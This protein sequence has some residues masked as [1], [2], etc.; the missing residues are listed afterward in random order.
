MGK[1]FSGF[2]DTNIFFPEFDKMWFIIGAVIMLGTCIS[3]IPQI[4]LIIKKKS[5]LGLNPVTIFIT[6]VNQFLSIMN[7]LSLH[8]QDFLGVLQIDFGFRVVSRLMTFFNTLSL[9]VAYLP[10]VYLNII[11]LDSFFLLKN[12]TFYPR[13]VCVFEIITLTICTTL[14]F[15]FI[16]KGSILGTACIAYGKIIGTVSTLIVF[17]Q[18]LPQI[19][20]TYKLKSSGALSVAMLCIQAPGGMLNAMFMM[21]GQNDDWT[22]W[23]PFFVASLDQFVLLG[24][25]IYF[26]KGKASIE[27]SDDNRLILSDD[28]NDINELE[29]VPH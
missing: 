8:A 3:V 27:D 12:R 20:T 23:F 18:Y 17:V 21:I 13:F 5:S 10:I 26:N 6:S 2:V 28:D 9:W 15:I 29:I 4:E 25:C 24:M 11:F 19:Y 14:L 1:S 22:T 7:I 16:C